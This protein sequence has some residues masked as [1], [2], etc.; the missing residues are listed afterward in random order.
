MTFVLSLQMFGSFYISCLL[1]F[2]DCYCRCLLVL[3]LYMACRYCFVVIVK[4]AAL[5]V[6]VLFVAH[7]VSLR[8]LLSLIPD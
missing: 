2:V 4:S 5:V 1:P 3:G 6:V 7:T 8:T